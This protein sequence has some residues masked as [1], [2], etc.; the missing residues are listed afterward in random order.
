MKILIKNAHIIDPFL[1]I[2]IDK[3]SILVE[4]G[5]IL[6]IS[7]TIDETPDYTIEEDNLVFPAFIDMHTHLREPGFEY[8]EDIESGTLAGIHGGFTTITAF[9]NTNPILD[10]VDKIQLVKERIEKKAKIRVLPI[11]SITK[12]Q[13][14]KELV[15]FKLLKDHV[16]GFTDDGKGIQDFNI[17]RKAMIEAKKY[18]ILLMLHEE[19]ERFG[20]GVVN[21]GYLSKKLGLEG[22]KSEAEESM[23]ARDIVLAKETGARIHFCHISTKLGAK[24]IK[25]GKEEGLNIT[26]EVT[27]HHLCFDETTF[28]DFVPNMKMSPPL[29]TRE[30]RLFLIDAFKNGIIDCIATDHAPHADHEKKDIKT[31]SFGITGLETAFVIIYNY[32]VKK[33]YLNLYD[34]IKGLTVN[35]AKTLG[36]EPNP[37]K[38]GNFANFVI[39]NKKEKTLINDEFF[40]SRSKNFPLRGELEGKITYLFYNK[41]FFKFINNTIEEVEF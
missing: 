40:F 8:K 25:I 28:E 15:D 14:G 3:T 29:R 19:D 37:I 5:K 24:L 30:D 17:A 26:A 21:Y 1:K 34:T 36:L 16:Y 41:K 32:L 27:P 18:N 9:P 38:E 11:A 10:S 7:N 31:A 12:N 23:I 22:I 13:E 35:P 6:K 20:K 33:G 2:E 4:N 39:F